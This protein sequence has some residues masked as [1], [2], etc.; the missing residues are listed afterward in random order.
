MIKWSEIQSE[1][2]GIATGYRERVVRLF[3]K[4]EGLETDEKI[5]G[6]VVTVN[7]TSFS[8]KLG[9]KQQTFS[10]WLKEF[11]LPNVGNRQPQN[12]SPT[13]VNDGVPPKNGFV[14]EINQ[15]LKEMVPI[16]SQLSVDV[17]PLI[18]EDLEETKQ[19]ISQ[20]EDK[21]KESV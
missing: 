11:G 19:L 21:M 10:G 3:E 16:I 14:Q 2:E 8:R 15:K 4:Y 5:R 12:A 13:C 7:A 1:Y 20:I 9:I 17:Y 18:Q 6:K